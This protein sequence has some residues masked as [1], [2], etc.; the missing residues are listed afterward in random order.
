MG[1]CLESLASLPNVDDLDALIGR[2]D[3]MEQ[4]AGL[5]VWAPGSDSQFASGLVVLIESG[6][7]E[8]LL[9]YDRRVGPP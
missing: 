8:L 3:I 2:D 5:D 9:Y 6:T 4:E 7:G 1:E